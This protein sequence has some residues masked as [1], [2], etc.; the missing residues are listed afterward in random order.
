MH[1]LCKEVGVDNVVAADVSEKSVN[2]PCHVEQ[3]DVSDYA[4]YEKIV[5]E[6]KITYIIHLAAI[7]SAL[8]ERFPDRANLVNVTGFMNALNLARDNNCKIYSP[9][10]IA[11]F[12]GELFPRIN[13]PDDT[14]L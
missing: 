9:S 3:L 14:I 6:H 10:S 4:K 12:G 2:L 8:G 1:A 5:K 13:T 11:V 7:L